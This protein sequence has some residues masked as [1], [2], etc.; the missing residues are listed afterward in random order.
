[1]SYLIVVYLGM[2]GVPTVKIH[3]VASEKC[4]TLAKQ[5]YN[6]VKAGQVRT[7]CLNH[8]SYQ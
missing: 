2:Q 7:F 3:E 6:N 4:N 8:R 1:M 5:I